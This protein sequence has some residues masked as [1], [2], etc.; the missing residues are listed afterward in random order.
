M[1][2]ASTDMKIAEQ[3]KSL[4]DTDEA[5]VTADALITGA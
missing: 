4:A 1:T 5:Q 3:V 2:R